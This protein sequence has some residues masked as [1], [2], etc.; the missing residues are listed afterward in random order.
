MNPNV[1]REIYRPKASGFV[2]HNGL[3]FVYPNGTSVVFHNVPDQGPSFCSYADFA[4][5]LPV[6]VAREHRDNVSAMFARA[7]QLLTRSLKYGVLSFNCE[8]AVRIV[9]DGVA[10]SPQVK[11]TVTTGVAAG[12]LT[13]LCG[14]NGKQIALATGIGGTVGLAFSKSRLLRG[15]HVA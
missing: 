12:L 11:S 1:V 5:G 9:V 8:Q 7:E 4:E 13:W 10:S 2:A 3:E 14:G 15:G 6:T